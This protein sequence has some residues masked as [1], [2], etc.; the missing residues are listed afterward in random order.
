MVHGCGD[1]EE[2]P[3]FTFI[4]V[5]WPYK[6]SRFTYTKQREAA[7]LRIQS[8]PISNQHLQTRG[9]ITI[10]W[11]GPGAAHEMHLLPGHRP[12]PL[13]LWPGCDI[14]LSSRLVWKIWLHGTPLHL[15][16]LLKCFSK[17]PAHIWYQQ[18]PGSAAMKAES[19]HTIC[20][21]TQVT[22]RT[23]AFTFFVFGD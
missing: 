10:R 8:A 9:H 20:Q 12:S 19:K 18:G 14:H 21:R 7:A 5:L 2:S 3:I 16:C 22:D 4:C 17:L 11:A 23:L 6:Q 1:S 13:W 15:H